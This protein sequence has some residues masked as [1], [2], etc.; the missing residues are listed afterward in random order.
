M[1]T[2]C[3][4]GNIREALDIPVTHGINITSWHMRPTV[5]WVV[6][7]EVSLCLPPRAVFLS[8]SLCLCIAL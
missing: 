7:I 5:S 1:Q 4:K 3:N 8:L 2:V 6:G